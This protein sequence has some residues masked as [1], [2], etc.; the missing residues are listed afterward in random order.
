LIDERLEGGNVVGVPAREGRP[1]LDNIASA[2]EYAPLVELAWRL[3]VAA[4]DIEVSGDEA[5]DEPV[6][7]LLR[8]PGSGR[9][10]V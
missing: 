7:N 3:V 1:V 4:Q 10:P 8:G 6:R 5:G 2:P 9:L